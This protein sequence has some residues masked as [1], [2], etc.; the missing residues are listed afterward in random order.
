MRRPGSRLD[1]WFVNRDD[2][3]AKLAKDH[4]R[5][6]RFRVALASGLRT[7]IRLGG[8]AALPFYLREFCLGL[9]EEGRLGG[10][11]L[12][13]GVLR[14]AHLL[15]V[16]SSF[17]RAL[18]SFAVDNLEALPIVLLG[19]AWAVGLAR[20][21]RCSRRGRLVFG[22]ALGVMVSMGSAFYALGRAETFSFRI[23]PRLPIAVSHAVTFA[24]GAWIAVAL[25]G[26]II[27]VA[28]RSWRLAASLA[29]GGGA[30]GGLA[31]LA[32]DMVLYA[33]G[34][35]VGLGAMPEVTI[36]SNLGAAAAAGG[37]FGFALASHS[38]SS[39]ST[40]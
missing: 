37:V 30:I 6:R 24:L 18:T 14:V 28:L 27:G 8:G 40:A 34:V 16:P 17:A 36:L 39:S 5:P 31:F 9:T 25:T 29:L 10:P 3:G 2:A 23:L 20:L 13:I 1:F 12:L 21:T 32:T 35:R 22:A 26:A 19:S 38:P 33:F 4:S 7:A 11:R 15:P